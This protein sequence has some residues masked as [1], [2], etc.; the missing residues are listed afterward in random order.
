M[1]PVT[2]NDANV[3]IPVACTP[4]NCEPLPRKKLPEILPVALILPV[5]MLP[6]ALVEI[7]PVVDKLVPVI[8]P[9]TVLA[10]V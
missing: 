3:P 1:L 2:L 7:L 6:V 9:P 8:T 10:A 4:V 5:A